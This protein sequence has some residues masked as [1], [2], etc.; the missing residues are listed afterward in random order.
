MGGNAFDKQTHCKKKK[1]KNER[2][3]K[4]QKEQK[5]FLCST[6]FT[7]FIISGLVYYSYM[8]TLNISLSV[9]L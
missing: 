3:R 6:K 7:L 1:R 2:K 8:I 5:I 4:K 9:T